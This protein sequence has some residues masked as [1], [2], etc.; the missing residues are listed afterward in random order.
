MRRRPIPVVLLFFLLLPAF[1]LAQRR[2]G[3]QQIPQQQ[4]PQQ[5]TDVRVRLVRENDRPLDRRIMVQLLTSGGA[6]ISQ[7]MT[8]DNGEINFSQL[9]PGNYQVAV[10]D[11]DFEPSAQTFT[12]FGG[13]AMHTETLR[14]KPK[15]SGSVKVSRPSGAVVSASEFNIPAKA[16]KE[17]DKG[18]DLLR[19]NKPEEAR[20]H[21]EK[22][23]ALY[24]KYAAAY[25]NL[26]VI[27]MRA[28]DLP[29]A[30]DA[31]THALAANPQNSNAAM[32]MAR[33]IYPQHDWPKIEDLL[34]RAIVGEPQNAEAL[35]MLAITEYS[36]QKWADAVTYAQ[37]VHSL[38]HDNYPIVHFLAA[39]SLVNLDKPLDAIA[40]YKIFLKEAPNSASA[41][42]AQQELVR[43][44]EH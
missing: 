36:L 33:L 28:N 44:Q 11:S 35:T 9:D 31:F 22:A 38:S 37:R 10:N 43:L 3:G 40:E 2:G 20:A 16:L 12:L 18:N 4:Q 27:W 19:D 24:P 25:N 21:Y 7:N 34:K 8:D 39:R 17:F 30:R 5:K 15:S 29:K 23:V 6:M 1:S 42:E 13:E 14:V 32:N 41:P 26:G